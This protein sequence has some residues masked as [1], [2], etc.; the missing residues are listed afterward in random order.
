M[1]DD[2]RREEERVSRGL[3][4]TGKVSAL[5]GAGAVD[6]WQLWKTFPGADAS[7]VA[8]LSLRIDYGEVFGLLG[9]N[10]AGKTTTLS[11]MSGALRPSS[12]LCRVGGYDTTTD[13]GMRLV[14]RI[15]GFCPQFD[16]VWDE[17]T[18]HQ[19][20]TFYARLKGL[21]ITG[22]AGASASVSGSARIRERVEV[23]RVAEKVNL[24]GDS[25]HMAASKLSGGMRRRLSLGISLLGNPPVLMLDEPTTGLDPE[26][27]RQLWDIVQSE[28]GAGRSIIITTHSMEEAD[29]LCS[30]IGIMAKGR[31]R[32]IGSQQHLKSQFGDGYK[33]QL[34]LESDSDATEIAVTRFVLESVC[35]EAKLTS[36]LGG[37][38]AF[39]IP[40]EQHDGTKVAVSR[41]FNA[42][43]AN[44]A[45]I[46]VLN[47][48]ITQASLE[49]V[50]VKVATRA[51]AEEE[52]GGR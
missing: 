25:M 18:V 33:L 35:S 13:D 11:M 15:L 37:T 42:M 9:P 51:E 21:H 28:R 12:G 30:R 3:A 29:T 47:W 16:V 2:V 41:I 23:Q 31:M 14:H 44:K 36:K 5:D 10:G 38:M 27:R 7:A 40:R 46:G 43:E 32:C 1:R 20:L 8:G 22:S 24:D 26:T 48:G 52:E 6:L 17:L 4:N 19:H 34:G 50:F 49:E 39:M 45:A